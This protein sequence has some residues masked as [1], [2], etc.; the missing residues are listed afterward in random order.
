MILSKEQQSL[1][2]FFNSF[3]N[4]KN[5]Y[6]LKLFFKIILEF[7]RNLNKEKTLVT[8][9]LEKKIAIEFQ[10]FEIIRMSN[11]TL[12]LLILNEN[13]QE[14]ILKSLDKSDAK[15]HLSPKGTTLYDTSFELLSLHGNDIA[16][17]VKLSVL[18]LK[19]FEKTTEQAKTIYQDVNKFLDI[20]NTPNTIVQKLENQEEVTDIISLQSE[21]N[22]EKLLTSE[23]NEILEFKGSLFWE[24]KNSENISRNVLIKEIAGFFNSQGGQLVYGVS[25]SLELL[26]ISNDLAKVNNSIDKLELRVRDILEFGIGKALTSRVKINFSDAENKTVMILTTPPSPVP[27]FANL[28]FEICKKHKNSPGPCTFCINQ[29]VSVSSGKATQGFF[30]RNGNRVNMLSFGEM[31]E[32]AKLHWPEFNKG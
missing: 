26:G 27:V 32:Y 24:E 12:Q 28:Y 19:N 2:S 8:R 20:D 9:T 3:D 31:Y 23:E 30:V 13:K 10:G 21:V 18:Y 22:I 17:L 14:K 5:A 11:F 25:D 1:D 16:S 15:E 6:N 29:K 4:E 7:C